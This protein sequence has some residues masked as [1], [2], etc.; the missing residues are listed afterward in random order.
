MD[1]ATLPNGD[2][3]NDSMVGEVQ[4]SY[5]NEGRVQSCSY[6]ADFSQLSLTVFVP[7]IDR[8]ESLC[9]VLI[10]PHSMG[11]FMDVPFEAT[12]IHK[13]SI[14]FLTPENLF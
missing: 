13:I 14:Q 3:Q 6:G 8:S 11:G 1:S 9:F 5:R 2:A 4:V 10:P 7:H 12:S